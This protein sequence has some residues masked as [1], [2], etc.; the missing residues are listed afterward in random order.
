MGE[1]LGLKWTDVNLDVGKVS[2]RRSL[3]ITDSGLD[4]GSPKN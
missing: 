3:K 4:F 2:V 1:L